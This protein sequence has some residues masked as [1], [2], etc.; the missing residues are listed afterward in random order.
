VFA[1]GLLACG[2]S[3]IVKAKD[4]YLFRV[5]Y[6]KGQVV[7]FDTFNSVVSKGNPAAGMT[8]KVSM[9]LSVLSVAK[10][11]ATVRLT[12]GAGT[13]ANSTKQMT[14]PQSV[15]VQLDSKDSSAVG[16]PKFPNH[17][18]QVGSTWTAVRPVNMGG[19]VKRLD[20]VYKFAGIKTVNGKQLA[21]VTYSL[22]GAANGSG[23]MMLLSTDASLYSNET[24]IS[25]PGMDIA[26]LRIEM[27]RRP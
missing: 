19:E 13:L 21:V 2:N 11:V 22:T 5:K 20:A 15:T 25:V 18:V 10:G 9:T 26:K 6:S 3:Q 24:L 14:A 16:G 12:M 1:A 23:T 4:G 27:K 17:P 8:V 7:K